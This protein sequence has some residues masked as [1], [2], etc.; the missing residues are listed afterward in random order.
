ML[1]QKWMPNLNLRHLYDKYFYLKHV[2]GT[3]N[4]MLEKS[5]KKGKKIIFKNVDVYAE[6]VPKKQAHSRIV[7]Q[8]Q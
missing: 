4:F 1:V 3:F 2:L 8:N 6:Q 5:V 7:K